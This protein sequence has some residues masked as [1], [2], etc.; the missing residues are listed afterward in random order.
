LN[1]FKQVKLIF[2][3][4]GTPD[5]GLFEIKARTANDW[6]EVYDLSLQ[7]RHFIVVFY[8]AQK[9]NAIRQ[10]QQAQDAFD[11]LFW[12]GAPVVVVTQYLSAGNGVNLQYWSSR[13]KTKRLDFIHIGLLETPYFYFGKPDSDL[14]WEDKMAL[15]KENIWYQAKLY[16]GNVIT[17]QRFL[18]VLST[19]ND[20]WEWN[21]RYQDDA[22]T[23]FD[24]LFNH[25]S[26]FIQAL[27]RVERIWGKCPIRRHYSASR[28]TVTFSGFALPSS[29]GSG[30]TASSR[31]GRSS[32]RYAKTS[33]T[34]SARCDALKT[35]AWE[36][37][38]NS[39]GWRY[40]GCSAAWKGYARGIVIRM[41][42]LSGNT[43]A[44]PS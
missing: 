1:T 9:G 20:P 15:L 40:K 12:E 39:A 29:I 33:R 11:A 21:R 19:L 2:D 6:F 32:N 41:H 4:Y 27:G 38:T 37:K 28:C 13:E 34:S 14:T 17:E 7:E 23:R 25:M 42:A 36:G 26:T 18:Q 30:R 3:R 43:C 22:N 44:R 31:C 35:P 10:N 8:N 24:A 5:G 16:T